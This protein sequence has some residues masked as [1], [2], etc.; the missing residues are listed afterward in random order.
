MNERDKILANKV[1]PMCPEAKT[2]ADEGNEAKD[3]GDIASKASIIESLCK[4]KH[5]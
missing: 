1:I 3:D 4:Q 5:K 2:K